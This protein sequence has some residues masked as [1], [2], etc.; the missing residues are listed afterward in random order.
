MKHLSYGL[1]LLAVFLLGCTVLDGRRN[2]GGTTG[3]GG[4]VS[5]TGSGGNTGGV[6]GR[7]ATQGTG[8]IPTSC[9]NCYDQGLQCDSS[10][11]CADC[12]A[13]QDCVS[14]TGN[15]NAVCLPNNKCG[16]D[17]DSQC[18]GLSQGAR[19]VASLQNCGCES[20]ADCSTAGALTCAP[21]HRC[22]C[23]S[24]QDCAGIA[25]RNTPLPLCDPSTGG[26]VQCLT[27]TDCTDPNNRVCDPTGNS[28]LPCRTSADCAQN[29]NG[30]VCGNLGM[31]T[32]GIGAC[33]CNTDQDCAGRAGGPHCVSNGSPYNKCGC[34]TDADCAGDPEGFQCINPYNDDWLQCGCGTT[35]DCPSGKECNQ[36]CQ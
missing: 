7:G 16:C 12:L 32:T 27:D 10:G 34:V 6:G 29:A 1:V 23:S 11:H 26:C 31:Y 5:T 21:N 18:A 3:A 36:Y 13:N 25:F 35:A 19:C 28:C 14:R 4:T 20:D 2:G 9:Y 24:N 22:G 15:P 30:P 8:G 33:Y 17:A